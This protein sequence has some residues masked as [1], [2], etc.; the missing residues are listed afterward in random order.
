MKLKGHGET[1]RYNGPQVRGPSGEN[2]TVY[3]V[4]ITSVHFGAKTV[5]DNVQMIIIED[6]QN[7]L[8]IGASTLT[9]LRKELGIFMGA[10]W[11][12]PNCSKSN[13]LPCEVSPNSVFSLACK[14]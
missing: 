6:L 2:L 10:N 3:G 7:P 1:I 12:H 8:I 9:V 4:F 14:I 13:V 5:V 11:H